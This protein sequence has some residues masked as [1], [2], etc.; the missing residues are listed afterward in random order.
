MKTEKDICAELDILVLA[1]KWNQE[2]KH[3]LDELERLI[4]E[5]KAGSKSLVAFY[6]DLSREV[7]A[8]L[9]KAKSLDTH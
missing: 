3:H 1:I 7:N 5:T 6:D 9:K 2:V 4:L 8:R